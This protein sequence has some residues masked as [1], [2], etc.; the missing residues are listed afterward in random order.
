MCGFCGFINS[1]DTKNLIKQMTKTLTKKDFN[2]KNTY[3]DETI[4][5]SDTEQ[6]YKKIYKI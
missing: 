1:N 6:I 3:I 5:L 2:Y 4:S